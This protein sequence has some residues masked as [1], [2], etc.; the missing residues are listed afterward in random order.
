MHFP[1]YW[2]R[3][4]WNGADPSG[5]PWQQLAWDHSDDSLADAKT[6]AE[7]KARRLGEKA[8][9]SPHDH[10]GGYPYADRALREPVLR[11]VE[12]TDG[13]C[14]AVV[15]RTAYGS[16]VLNAE[17]LM[18]IDVDLPAA[19]PPA[20]GGLVAAILSLFKGK[21]AEPLPAS[22][23]ADATLAG[24][25][26]WQSSNLTWAFRV[27]RTHSG[28]RY[29]AISDWHDPVGDATHQVLRSLDCDPRYQQL[30]K[31][32]KS[33][34]ARLTP[35]PWRCGY[36]NPPERF[37]YEGSPR[38][39]RMEKWL[40]GYERASAGFGTCQYVA[41]VGSASPSSA[42]SALIAEHDKLTK[43]TSGLPLA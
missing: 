3:G 6:K 11:T 29:I 22:P 15:T 13:E 2:A 12:G 40:A 27:Y 31:V 26:Q 7:A 32:Q 9:R 19:T 28:W 23:A 34:R 39:S 37:P 18:F 14:A 1:K 4:E 36:H 43:A 35:K 21:P 30:C 5:N 25:R 16:E 41:T 20:G 17:K 33:F 38:E 10:P 42:M 24:L 8:A